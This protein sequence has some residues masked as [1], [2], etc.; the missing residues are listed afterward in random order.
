MEEIK[1]NIK[2]NIDINMNSLEEFDRLLI[3]SDKAS[4]YSVEISKT[5]SMIKVVME[6]KGDKKEFIYKDYSGKIGEQI[7]LMIK[8]LM[9]K[10]NNKNYQKHY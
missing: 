7:L 4:E 6:Y 9:L 2:S 10:M 1:I 5:D 8:N 3:S